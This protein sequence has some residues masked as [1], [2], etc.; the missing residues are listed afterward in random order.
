MHNNDIWLFHKKRGEIMQK[1]NHLQ[2]T[3][4]TLM[5]IIVLPGTA[6]F[7]FGQRAVSNETQWLQ[8]G[9]LHSFFAIEGSEFEACRTGNTSDNQTDGLQWPAQFSCQDHSVAKSMWIGTTN[10]NDP[11]SETT[12]PHKVVGIGPR[13]FEGDNNGII[14]VKIDL[15][16][17]SA[18]PTVTVDGI[19]A[20]DND[21]FDQLEGIFPGLKSDRMIANEVHSSVGITVKRRLLAFS[22]QYHNNYFIYEYVFVNDG[23]I[24]GSGGS[25]PQ[26]LTDCIFHFQYRY[27]FG[28][29]ASIRGWA[30]TPYIRWGGNCVNHVVGQDPN[31]AG[32]EF[33]AQYSWYGLCS[34]SPVSDW[35]CPNPYAPTEL[36]AV[37]Y[38]GI[39]ILHADKSASDK[40]DDPFQP[41]TTQFTDSDGSYNYAVDQY[42]IT[43]MTN[44]YQIMAQGHPEKTHAEEV[45]DGYA[46]QWGNMGG[47]SQGQGFG[48]YT[49]EP[50]D[51]IKIVVAEAV[52]GLCRE[53]NLEVATNWFNDASPF[54]LPHGSTTTDRDEYKK[55]WVQTGVDSIYQT[56]RRAISNFESGYNIPQP[57]PPPANFQ[58]E[59]YENHIQ[60]AWSNNA[61]S[62]PNFD[63]YRIYRATVKPDTFYQLIFEC[64][65]SSAVHTYDD[66]SVVSGMDYYYYIQSKDD[67]STN[68]I[69]PGIPL[70]SSKFF[71]MTNLPVYL[72]ATGINLLHSRNKPDCYNLMQNY[73][74]PFN[75]LTTIAYTL[76]RAGNVRITIYNLRGEKI[77]DLVNTT[78]TEGNHQAFWNAEKQPSG[79]YLCRFQTH[80]F[81]STKKI[82]LQK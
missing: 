28:W 30:P 50:G 6:Q 68:D 47:Y 24:D 73:P 75:A 31:A 55:Q 46:D 77:A 18:S 37:Q 3:I 78:K 1:S 61:V 36:G 56:F 45:G 8:I 70:V 22:Q 49:L 19:P 4:L 16:G 14:P 27:S 60:L 38:T 23:V 40:S 53:K 63:G 7:V 43:R 81:N 26:V 58:V 52:S 69:E 13:L 44:Q 71:T 64:D 5:L 20:S 62:H 39:V 32:F 9:S 29:E 48:P 57:P 25:N 65:A 2:N 67:G 10:F 12:F 33:R 42:D 34:Y 72:G 76:P 74:N 54:T 79:I 66:M 21:A 15:L 59:S 17:K 51:S 82:I 41:I 80:D 11:V 35:G